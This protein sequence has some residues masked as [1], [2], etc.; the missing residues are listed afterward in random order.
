MNFLEKHFKLIQLAISTLILFIVLSMNFRTCAI[1]NDLRSTKKATKALNEKV[2]TQE[3]L[4]KQLQQQ[5]E[6][7]LV[8]E[9]EMDSKNYK[10]VKKDTIK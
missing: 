10:P 9:K 6:E 8:R 5:S 1:N 3:D 4:N 7:I 2:L